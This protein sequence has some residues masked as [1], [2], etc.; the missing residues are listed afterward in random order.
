VLLFSLFKSKM[1]LCS[2]KLL[3]IFDYRRFH[4]LMVCVRNLEQAINVYQDTLRTNIYDAEIRRYREV[5]HEKLDDFLDR[6]TQEFEVF[7][8]K[9]TERI[10]Q[11]ESERGREREDLEREITSDTHMVKFKPR[12]ELKDYLTNERLVALEERIEEAANFRKELDKLSVKETTRLN[13]NM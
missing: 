1:L 8:V 6:Y 4:E 7:T 2:Q 11:F 9:K 10:Y 5:G 3:L 13:K 12:R